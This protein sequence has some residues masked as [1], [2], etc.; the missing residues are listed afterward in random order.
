MARIL[1][2]TAVVT[3]K[4]LLSYAFLNEPR[5]PMNG[6]EPVYSCCVIIPKDDTETVNAIKE[7]LNNTYNASASKFGGKLPNKNSLKMPLRDGDEDRADNDLYKNCYFI[8]A[9]TKNRPRVLDTAKHEITDPGQIYSGMYAKVILNFFPY[10]TNGS[11]GI[12][13]ALGDM[14][15]V[16]DGTRLSGGAPSG[17]SVFESSDEGGDNGLPF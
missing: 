6:G 10:A 17:E 13:C 1:N 7:A 5:V 15:K 4:A 2:N 9:K 3:N 8:N 11:K 16:A 12:S 14:Q